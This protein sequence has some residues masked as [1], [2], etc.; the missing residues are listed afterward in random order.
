MLLDHFHPPLKDTRPW[1]GFFG[2]WAPKVASAINRQL[3]DGWFA[4]PTVKWG[5][6]VDVATFEEAA[7]A[8]AA[9]HSGGPSSIPIPAPTRTVQFAVTTDVVEVRVYRD[10]EELIL[11]GAIE[12]VSPANKDRPET[13]EEFVAKCDA[14]LRDTVGLAIVDTVTT[15][16]ANLHRQLMLR[17]GEP[18][19]RDDPLYT[20]AY[21]PLAHEGGAT[22]SFWYHLLQ[23]G[24]R[25]PDL[26]LFLKNGPVVEVPLHE[27]YCDTCRELRIQTRQDS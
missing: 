2:T 4:A 16:R 10:L 18:D 21:R 11:A 22:L 8:T 12:F 7:A 26:L 14:Y 1:T 24:S 23:L 27:T 20:V 19:D 3:P 13:R 5:I 17:L 9:L 15:R 6:E 25:L